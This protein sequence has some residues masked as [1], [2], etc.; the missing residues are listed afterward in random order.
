MAALAEG[1]QYGLSCNSL[2]GHGKT[3]LLLKLTDS[4]LR[5][6]EEFRKLKAKT[7]VKPSIQFKGNQGVISLPG[8]TSSD[9]KMRRNTF[10]FNMASYDA[11]GSLECVHQCRNR[12]YKTHMEVQGTIQ[13]KLKILATDEVYQ[14]TKDKMALA[15][16]EMKKSTTNYIDKATGKY[17]GNKV[18]VKK[19]QNHGISRSNGIRPVKHPASKPG[20]MQAN[21][22]LHKLS[23]RDRIIHLLALKPYK[24]PELVLRLQRDHVN[25]K[26]KTQLGSILQQVA[27]MKDNAFTLNKHLYNEV[28]EDWPLY[29]EDDKQ[30]IRRKL[31]QFRSGG[32]EPSPPQNS[33]HSLSPSSTGSN[34]SSPQKRPAEPDIIDPKYKKPRIA[35]SARPPPPTYNNNNNNISNGTAV[36]STLLNIKTDAVTST[37]LS[38]TLDKVS[39]SNSDHKH[40]NQEKKKHMV[41]KD[42]N[43][44]KRKSSP[45]RTKSSK[46]S[47]DSVHRKTSPDIVRSQE[48]RLHNGTSQVASST[49]TIPEYMIKYS[50]IMSRDARQRYKDDFNAEYNEYRELHNKV[51]TITKKFIALQNMLEETPEGS[52]NYENIKT[53]VIEEYQIIQK[54][55][56]DFQEEKKRCQTLHAK[57]AH[58]KKLIM[59]YDQRQLMDT[60]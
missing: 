50:Q 25:Q 53:K 4:S 14:D 8:R 52:D 42:K 24:K 28:K 26:D 59:E 48:N 12:N 47:L 56:P 40:K 44:D 31:A 45:P 39:T 5:A 10:N 19:S 46:V 16:E 20:M 37:R 32:S 29:S 36:N 17:I 54:K 55:H 11:P 18:K 15:Q 43:K 34:P 2:A 35:H 38:P 51:D 13:T 6:I 60:S 3:V 58:I 22:K 9:G 41:D 21:S 23:Y 30:L 33:T 27:T 1:E 7:C 49:S 57:L